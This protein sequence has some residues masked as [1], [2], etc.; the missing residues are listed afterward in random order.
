MREAMPPA[1]SATRSAM[2]RFRGSNNP[3]P[4]EKT[5]TSR[6][7]DPDVLGDWP[8]TKFLCVNRNSC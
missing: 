4:P 6:P 2:P 7:P 5:R 8:A 1:A 3:A